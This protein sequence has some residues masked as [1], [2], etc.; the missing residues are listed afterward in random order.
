M[1]DAQIPQTTAVKRA[2][3]TL[4][5]QWDGEPKFIGIDGS[6]TSYAANASTSV[7]QIRNRY[8]ACENAV[9]FVSDSPDGPWTVADSVPSDDIDAIPPSAPVYNVKYV[10]IYDATPDARLLRL[11]A[12]LRGRLPVA[13]HGR[14]GHGLALPAVGRAGLLVAAPVHVGPRRAL[15]PVDGMGLRLLVELP[16]LQR[17]LRLGRLVPAARLVPAG[18]RRL[19]RRLA[20]SRRLG[21]VRARRLSPARGHRGPLL[22]RA[23]AAARGTGRS[24]TRGPAPCV[25]RCGPFPACA[26][27]SASAR[28]RRTSARPRSPTSTTASRR[29]RATSPRPPSAFE[30]PKTVD[31]RGP[32]TSTP[33]GTARSTAARR[34]ASGSSAR[35]DAGRRATAAR[36]R[37]RAARERRRV[38]RPASSRP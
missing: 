31:G 19:G 35:P 4:Q 14:L 21:L 26:R 18:V 33:T 1:L 38:R 16:V 22:G 12:G 5:V 30:R 27:A 32:T 37:S 7:L 8:Y 28:R 2:E 3:A 29:S 17:E 13:R 23:T 15:Q 11:H 9:W 25:P 34:K 24:R 36:P 6:A 10:R 20:S